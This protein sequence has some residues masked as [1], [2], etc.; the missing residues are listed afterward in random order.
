MSEIHP[1]QIVSFY[2]DD[3]NPEHPPQP[4]YTIA[5]IDSGHFLLHDNAGFVWW[6]DDPANL[7]DDL[8]LLRSNHDANQG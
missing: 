5:N 8:K 3:D 6:T 1:I 4:L 7:V 2:L